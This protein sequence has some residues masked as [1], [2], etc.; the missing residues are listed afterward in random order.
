MV[1]KKVLFIIPTLDSGGIE[2]YLLRFLA[3]TRL[4]LS[5][6]TVLI[7][8]SRM[9]GSLSDKYRGLGVVLVSMP[10]GYF[11]IGRVLRFGK[12]LESERFDVICDFNANFAGLPMMIAQKVGI[13][14][15]IAFYRQGKNH[16]D[17]SFLKNIY[18]NVIKSWVN[19]YSTVVLS[20][21]YS[22]LDVYFPDRSPA[23][24]RFKVI[25]NS[26][27]PN[28]FL[29]RESKASIRKSFGVSADS[30]VVGH[31]GRVDRAKNHDS[32][33]RTF[34][35]VKKLR[36]D[37]I[38]LLCGKGVNSLR[39]ET[40]R[41][42]IANE[43]ICYEHRNDVPRFLKSLDH[44]IFPSVTEGQPNALIEAMVAGI[45][46]TASNIAP[47]LEC[48]PT[49]ARDQLYHFDD[50]EGLASGVLRDTNNERT[51]EIVKYAKRQF[52]ANKNFNLF[53]KELLF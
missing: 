42:G 16:Y 36:S 3:Y 44:F 41:L 29:I 25:R 38:L 21:S 26:L 32:I 27:Y 28:K 34:L 12:F 39:S 19:S 11:S 18:T 49:F 47:I 31:L 23:D 17:K 33:L 51:I 22:A 6:I 13:P 24:T 9:D 40:Q 4:N 2:T 52:D 1:T 14:I 8:T 48:V 35:K 37:A 5:N 30:F 15:R 50:I 20:N 7:R 10:L 46:F 45:P 53:E 43:V